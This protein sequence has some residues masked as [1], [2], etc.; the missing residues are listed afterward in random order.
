M[1]AADDPSS[2]KK[3]AMS[4]RAL[5]LHDWARAG[6]EEGPQRVS[7]EQDIAVVGPAQVASL[8]SPAAA[9]RR[10]V[11]LTP[12]RRCL[13]FI[14]SEALVLLETKGLGTFVLREDADLTPKGSHEP[15][16]LYAGIKAHWMCCVRSPDAQ[17]LTTWWPSF[18]GC[19]GRM[20]DF[21]KSS[22]SSAVKV[23]VPFTLGGWVRCAT[24]SSKN[25]PSL[26]EPKLWCQ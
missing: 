14:V 11:S 4:K 20:S 22:V 17:T 1:G 24:R 7:L 26:L 9:R 2:R 18:H 10:R 5:A 21:G 23:G 12:T 15:V 3:A 13:P 25:L 16:T 6:D 8:T 19:D